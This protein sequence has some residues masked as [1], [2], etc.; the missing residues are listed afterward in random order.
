MVACS[1]VCVYIYVIYTLRFYIYVCTIIYTCIYIYIYIYIICIWVDLSL[2]LY[3]YHAA[4]QNFRVSIGVD[5]L[6]L[7]PLLRKLCEEASRISTERVLCYQGY[8]LGSTCEGKKAR[9]RGSEREREEGV[10]H[11]SETQRQRPRDPCRGQCLT[12]LCLLLTA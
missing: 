7:T 1:C 10:G 3:L 2:Y 9:K 6:R 4:L 12:C 8:Y 5:Q 11:S